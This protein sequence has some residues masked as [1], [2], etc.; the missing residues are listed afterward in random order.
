MCSEPCWLPRLERLCRMILW[1]QWFQ[2][3]LLLTKVSFLLCTRLR[4]NFSIVF[5]FQTDLFDENK[6]NINCIE[7]SLFLKCILGNFLTGDQS[8]CLFCKGDWSLFPLKFNDISEYEFMCDKNHAV[9][10]TKPF[11][12]RRRAERCR[13]IRS[14]TPIWTRS[15]DVDVVSST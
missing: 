13:I 6:K 5:Q 2:S 12:S 9:I 1:F 7:N 3:A 10:K 8:R 15:S 14:I 11:K 4:R